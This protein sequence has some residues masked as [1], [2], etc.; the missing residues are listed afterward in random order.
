MRSVIGV[1]FGLI[2]LAVVGC[3]SSSNDESV[4]DDSSEV[5]EGRGAIEREIAPPLAVPTDAVVED[6]IG[7]RVSDVL[8]RV[9]GT[10]IPGAI[11][12]SDDCTTQSY[13]DATTKK[14]VVSTVE[15][16]RSSTVRVLAEDGTTVTEHADLNKDGK[17]D[18][19]SGKEGTF[20]QLT[21]TNFDGKVEVLIESV[22]D[23]ADFSLEGYG[24]DFQASRFLYRVRE[25]RDRDGKFE[26][27]KLVARG[28]LPAKP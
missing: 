6:K 15:C 20:V 24:E 2:V 4:T 18:R 16:E 23:L 10:A 7:V 17:I 26:H 11:E 1:G 9:K 14:P 8:A 12:K 28:L 19:W 27:E 22:A 13:V 5:N 25:D 21:D 3:S